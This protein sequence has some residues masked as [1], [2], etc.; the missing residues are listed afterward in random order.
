V[1]GGG[2][3]ATRDARLRHLFCVPRGEVGGTSHPRSP[4]PVSCPP[5]SQPPATCNQPSGGS[6]ATEPPTL[7]PVNASTPKG[8]TGHQATH[9][10]LSTPAPPALSKRA[11]TT[12]EPVAKSAQCGCLQPSVCSWCTGRPPPPS[13]LR[14]RV[15]KE[16]PSFRPGP[17]LTVEPS[18]RV[19]GAGTRWAT[20]CGTSTRRASGRRRRRGVRSGRTRRRPRRSGRR[21]QGLTLVHSSAQ[22]ETFLSLAPPSVSSNS[23]NEG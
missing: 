19:S 16:A 2:A 21:R 17:R 6:I 13:P 23:M 3:H 7:H 15:Y 22:P 14:A 4:S 9:F 12:A 11:A 10:T 8:S 18:P 5:S 20:L 1:T